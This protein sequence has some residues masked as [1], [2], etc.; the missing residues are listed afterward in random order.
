VAVLVPS[1]EDKMSRAV[2]VRDVY[3]QFD[4]YYRP[5]SG[6]LPRLGLYPAPE[7]RRL[8]PTAQMPFVVAL[9]HVSFC[10]EQGEIFSILGMGSS[11][12]T[13]LIRL[14]ATLLT[15]GSGSIQVFGYDTVR[16]PVQV[17]R[18]V[19]PV[20]AENSF[21]KR[22]SPLENL[23]GTAS[24]TSF[25]RRESR[26]RVIDLLTR[27]GLDQSAINQPMG[28]LSRADRQKVAIAR[29]LVFPPRLLLL[30]EPTYGLD[31]Q[32]R[33]DIHTVLHELRSETGL[34]I[35][36]AT[37]DPQ[38]AW[39]LGDHVTALNH[40]RIETIETPWGFESGQKDGNCGEPAGYLFSPSN[41]LELLREEA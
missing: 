25:K 26:K 33:Q 1:K 41:R 8:L 15:P 35:F 31:A 17:K 22:L 40:G 39:D 13:T 27:L 32:S 19:N 29:S 24:P 18:L 9:D 36:V 7:T 3:K 16:Q 23:I 30:D 10:I 38:E 28:A 34:T 20:A 11:G 14:L 21:F 2:I 5:V 4:N 6:K 37:S 12:K